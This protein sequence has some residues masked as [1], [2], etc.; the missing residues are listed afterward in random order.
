MKHPQAPQQGLKTTFKYS[1][2]HRKL[3]V[4]GGHKRYFKKRFFRDS[5][6]IQHMDFWNKLGVIENMDFL[7]D[8]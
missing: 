5:W 8:F 2:G 3:K 4:H 6:R 7:K 1:K